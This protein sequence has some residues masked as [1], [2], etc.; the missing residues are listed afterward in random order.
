MSR[1]KTNSSKVNLTISLIFHGALVMLVVFFAARE[2]MLGK[3]LKEITVTMAP[4]EKKP[5]PPKEKPPEPKVEPPKSAETP[6]VASVAPPP[7]V[8]NAAPPPPPVQDTPMAAPAAVN[9]PAMDFSDGAK[10]VQSVSDPNLIYKGLVEHALRSHW[11]RPEDMADE[12]FVAEVEIS[13][14]RDGNVTGSR[15]LKGTGDS[16]WDNSVKAAIAA[17]KVLSRPPPKG[18]PPSF[19]TR[20]DVES[21]RTEE[22]IHLSSK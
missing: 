8:Q 17:T 6:K 10:D 19:L 1:R 21:Q 3:K 13:V 2:G 9:L 12:K 20:F 18:F 15:W 14:D 4:K 16:R 5:E 7:L 22:V 11:N